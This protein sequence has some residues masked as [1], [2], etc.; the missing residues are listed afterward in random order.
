MV[1]AHIKNRIYAEVNVVIT[2]ALAFSFF[3]VWLL[4]DGWRILLCHF[5]RLVVVSLYVH[6]TLEPS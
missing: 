5:R 4:L 1:E 3:F 6:L 2:F